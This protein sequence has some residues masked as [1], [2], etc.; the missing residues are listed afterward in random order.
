MSS[1]ASILESVKQSLE[2]REKVDYPVI[3][4]FKHPGT[5]LL[6]NFKKAL[7][8]AAGTWHEVGSVAEAQ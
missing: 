3:P 8:G 2:N 7:Q 5:N 6:E 4:T 1:K